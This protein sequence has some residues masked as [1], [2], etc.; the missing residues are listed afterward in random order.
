MYSAALLMFTPVGWVAAIG[1]GLAESAILSLA[2]SGI[3]KLTESAYD[4]LKKSWQLDMTS[5]G[6]EYINYLTHEVA[7]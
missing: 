2:E 5:G 6:K 1:I 7:L 4:W 3:D